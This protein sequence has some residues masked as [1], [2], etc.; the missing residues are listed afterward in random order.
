MSKRIII[1]AHSHPTISQGG[2]EVAAYRQYHHMLAAGY[3]ARFVGLCTDFDL[4]SRLLSGAQWMIEV[5][6][7]DFL[8]RG[9]YGAYLQFSTGS[10]NWPRSAR[11]TL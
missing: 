4:T 5:E 1:I 8:T 11:A 3:D 10:L 6:P 9:E 7:G 2:G